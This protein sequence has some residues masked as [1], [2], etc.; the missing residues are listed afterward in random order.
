MTRPLRVLL[1]EDNPAD[2]DL[3]KETLEASGRHLDIVTV[4]DGAE[5]LAYLRRLTPFG[6]AAIPHLVLLDLNLP[7]VD[8]RAVL[9]EM[10]KHD[11]LRPVPVVVLTS[12]D[13]ERDIVQSYALGANSYVTKP[14]GLAA[15]QAAV[16]AIDDFWLTVVQL[17]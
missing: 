1:V 15:F 13:A 9:S 2:A 8:G 16:R 10:R 3:T 11:E 6:T 14:V 12:S 17:P 4:V 5:A 7:K